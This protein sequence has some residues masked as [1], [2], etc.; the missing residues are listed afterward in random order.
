MVGNACVVVAIMNAQ[1][2]RPGEGGSEQVRD[3]NR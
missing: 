2:R 1:K 3:Q